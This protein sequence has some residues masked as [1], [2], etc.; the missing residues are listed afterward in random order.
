[1]K[2]F[3]LGIII[4]FILGGGIV[5]AATYNIILQSSD[6]TAISSANPLPV[7]GY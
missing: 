7:E 6:G 1:M 2:S 3:I 4:G 5:Y